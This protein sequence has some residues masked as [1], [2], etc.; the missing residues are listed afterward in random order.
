MSTGDSTASTDDYIDYDL[1]ESI[2]DI[3]QNFK[4][5]HPT[6]SNENLHRRSFKTIKHKKHQQFASR[7]CD[8]DGEWVGHP[9]KENVN[10]WSNYS[11]CFTKEIKLLLDKLYSSSESDVQS[12]HVD[13]IVHAESIVDATV[14]MG[15]HSSSVSSR[16]TEAQSAIG[17]IPESTTTISVPSD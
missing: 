5:Q 17:L 16:F 6:T 15:Q 14:P 2:E 12:P 10:G 8:V 9:E 7:Q 13:S 4:S 1:E 3:A 11:D